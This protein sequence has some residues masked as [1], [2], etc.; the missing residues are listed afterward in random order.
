MGLLKAPVSHGRR[1]EEV[2]PCGVESSKLIIDKKRNEEKKH[3]KTKPRYPV[4]L[5]IKI[6]YKNVG[7]VEITK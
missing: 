5:K 6:V 7:Y 3:K 4:Q 2:E 1:G